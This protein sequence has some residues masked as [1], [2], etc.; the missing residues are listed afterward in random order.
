MK[1]LIII[2]V[3]LFW[4][5]GCSELQ[6]SY[7]LGNCIEEELTTTDPC[8]MAQS[9]RRIL[10]MIYICIVVF[11]CIFIAFIAARLRISSNSP[12]LNIENQKKI[13]RES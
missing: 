3:I 1:G 12:K 6:V 13:K 5:V 4:M 10:N 8:E 9:M 2:S 11:T 7:T